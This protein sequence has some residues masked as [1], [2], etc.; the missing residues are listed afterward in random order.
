MVLC[1][2]L[3]FCRF[4]LHFDMM[5]DLTFTLT[6]TMRPPEF[7]SCSGNSVGRCSVVFIS[8]QKEQ[9]INFEHLISFY[10]H[11]K[12]MPGIVAFKN[13]NYNYIGHCTCYWLFLCAQFMVHKASHIST[14]QPSKMH[15]QCRFASSIDTILYCEV[16]LQALFYSFL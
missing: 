1:F 3:S 9:H 7:H 2:K 11:C 6:F 14:V 13:L 10:L 12:L 16:Q 4:L 15:T 5:K 8:F